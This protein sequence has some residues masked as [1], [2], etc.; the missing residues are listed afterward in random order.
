MKYIE[1]KKMSKKQQKEI[2][3][4]TRKPPIPKSIISD[5]KAEF[6]KKQQR[7]EMQKI[8]KDNI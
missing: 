1:F 3:A 8:K 7:K 2:L 4:K 6:L 5:S